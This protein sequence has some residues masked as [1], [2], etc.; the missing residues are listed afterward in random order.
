[1][2]TDDGY[3]RYYTSYDY[4]NKS[5]IFNPNG[6]VVQY[7]FATQSLVNTAGKAIGGRTESRFYNGLPIPDEP[8][9]DAYHSLAVG[10]E[11]ETNVFTADGLRIFGRRTFW[12]PLVYAHGS[13]SKV[14][15]SFPAATVVIGEVVAID[16]LLRLFTT[17]ASVAR[18]FDA[19]II[20]PTVRQQFS[21]AGLPL[22]PDAKIKSVVAGVS[23]QLTSQD[24]TYC[25]RYAQSGDIELTSEIL[26]RRQQGYEEQTGSMVVQSAANRLPDGTLET[27]STTSTYAWTLPQY[28]GMLQ[29]RQFD[30]IA[31]TRLSNVSKNVTIASSITTYS[32]Q[33]GRA[34][35]PFDS[36]SDYEWNGAGNVAPE[37]NFSDPAANPQWLRTNQVESR[38]STGT[39]YVW[40]NALDVP[41]S[42]LLNSAAVRQIATFQNADSGRRRDGAQ[43]T[44]E[45]SYAGFESYEETVPW[46]TTG[47]G[48]IA[49]LVTTERA[50]TGRASL[51]LSN[52]AGAQGVRASFAA[53]PGVTHAALNYWLCNDAASG[54]SGKIV[55]R[56][57]TGAT[58]DIPFTATGGTWQ[59]HQRAIPIPGGPGAARSFTIDA[60]NA[61]AAAAVFLDDVMVFPLPGNAEAKVFDADTLLITAQ[62]DANAATTRSYYDECYNALAS[63]NAQG[64]VVQLASGGYSRQVGADELFDRQWPNTS[65]TVEASKGGSFESFN[66]ESWRTGWTA[67][68]ANA[69]SREPGTALAGRL[70]LTAGAGASL[71]WTGGDAAGG[72]ALR[73]RVVP[74][75][76]A[77]NAPVGVTIANV[78]KVEWDPSAG[79]LRIVDAAG[80]EIARKS[81]PGLAAADWIVTRTGA[82]LALYLDGQPLISAVVPGDGGAVAFFS[83]GNA[84]MA[85]SGLAILSAPGVALTFADGLAFTIQQQLFTEGGAIAGGALKDALGRAVISTKSMRYDDAMPRYRESLV[86]GFDWSSGIMTGDIADYYNGSD[87]RS[88]DA[89]YPYSRVVLEIGAGRAQAGGRQSRR[90]ARHLSWSDAFHRD[91]DDHQCPVRPRRRRGGRHLPGYRDARLR[92]RADPR[93]YGRP[94]VGILPAVHLAA[95]LRSVRTQE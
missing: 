22:A 24:R 76:S 20:P 81:R 66:D 43:A 36:V 3:Q 50:H 42:Q 33:W 19:G 83:A 85:I 86:T 45:C 75:Q 4:D 39:P 87:G 1:M 74:P 23:W 31:E 92:W 11:Y 16:G 7:P 67:A 70:V 56:F 84:G 80:R 61:G 13:A 73:A 88:N 94:A 9:L 14:G 69:W 35:A 53:R 89:G 10:R 5:A 25:A 46:R 78:G 52:D 47:G 82:A 12:R 64:Q 79:S 37:F 60:V 51:K 17:A 65:V 59:R 30:A 41:S 57:D 34:G 90:R 38:A 72:I 40:R 93:L 18:D 55:V 48:P 32:N 91:G 21:D 27:I 8:E 95:A 63:T 77:W 62:L 44:G 2:T 54:P 15:V 28:A 58:F 49:P 29:A 68:P 71:T 26:R 6:Q